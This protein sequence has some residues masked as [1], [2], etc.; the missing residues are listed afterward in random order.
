MKNLTGFVSKNG[1]QLSEFHS[2]IQ[3]LDGLYKFTDWEDFLTMLPVLD[4]FTVIGETMFTSFSLYFDE[5]YSYT[6]VD[7]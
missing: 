5:V 3:H 4:S 2:S 1:A 7:I 6:L